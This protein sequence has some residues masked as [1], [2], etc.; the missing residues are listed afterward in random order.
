MPHSQNPLPH[1]P[2]RQSHE[3]VLKSKVA[4]W[5]YTLRFGLISATPELLIVGGIGFY[6]FGIDGLAVGAFAGGLVGGIDFLPMCAPASS[7]RIATS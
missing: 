1:K 3:I 6:Y 7:Y 5:R 4:D 2:W